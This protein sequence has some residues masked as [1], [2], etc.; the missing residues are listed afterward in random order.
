[1]DNSAKVRYCRKCLLKDMDK[2]EYYKNVYDFI[3][4]LDEDVKAPKQE[5]ERRIGIC[6][7]CESL[8][9]GMCRV[10][11]CFVEMRAAVKNNYCPS[12]RDK[13]QQP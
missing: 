5:F 2:N 13:W 8:F 4:S 10:C 3:E 7:E 11:G 1:M 6:R 9:E 12:V